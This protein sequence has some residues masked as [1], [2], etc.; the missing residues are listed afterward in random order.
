MTTVFIAGSMNIKNLD[1]KV[2]ERIRK[3]V[4]SHFE[5]VVGDANG[6]DASIQQCLVD[7]GASNA[8]VYFSGESPRNNLGRWRSRSAGSKH[9]P[10]TRA[11]YT[12]KD[13]LMADVADYGLMVWDTRSTGTL[14]NV[15]ELLSRNKKAVVFINKK[16]DFM[17]VGDVQQL[18][19]LVKTM[20]DESKSRA[21]EKIALTRR[22]EDMKHVQGQMFDD[23]PQPSASRTNKRA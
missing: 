15:I 9:E 21:D 4:D 11:F 3:I 14:S 8:T 23:V 22:I 1:E 19:T 2:I 13:L 10:G 6:A 12:A 17:N 16:K 7:L 20:S 5:V 18:E